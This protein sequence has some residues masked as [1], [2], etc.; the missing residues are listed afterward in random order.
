MS[1]DIDFL[2]LLG[3]LPVIWE[4]V[5]G[6]WVFRVLTWFLMVY[7]VVLIVDVVLL[8]LMRGVT[9]NLKVQLYGTTRP[10]LSKNK[11]EDRFRSIERRLESNNPSQYKVAVLEAD[12][13]ADEVL[14]ES[15]YDGANMGERLAGIQPGQLQS[16]EA[17]KAAH[18]VRNRIVNEQN[19]MVSR[20]EAQALVEE[21]KQLF[22]E[23]ELFT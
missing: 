8:V 14:R 10:I 9:E 19:F 11:A 7:T 22:R 17:L 6:S 18:T 12:Q 2:S 1:T 3:I 5:Q 13:F 16:Y 15:G 20:E 23:L 4:A 21:Y